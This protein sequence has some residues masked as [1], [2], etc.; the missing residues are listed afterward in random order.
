MKRQVMKQVK[1]LQLGDLIHVQWFDASIG[2]SICGDN[3]DIPVQSWGI[4]LGVMGKK[5]KHIILAQ[6]NFKY[7]DGFF[8]I[9][10]TAIP[11]SWTNKANL[12]VS[13]AI[14]LREAEQ[15]LK[16]FLMGKRRS[17]MH[18]GKVTNHA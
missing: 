6:N 7:A 16:S 12:I 11:L 3:I 5:N 2:K 10:Y 17:R 8:D 15:L 9:D 13:G 4:Y 1:T 14:S 18:Q